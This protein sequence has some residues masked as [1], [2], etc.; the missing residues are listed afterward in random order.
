M[1][2][3]APD[4]EISIE[5]VVEAQPPEPPLAGRGRPRFRFRG[6]LAALGVVATLLV[7]VAVLPRMFEPSSVGTFERAQTDADQDVPMWLANALATAAGASGRAGAGAELHETLRR[8][9]DDGRSAFVFRSAEE[10]T[11]CMAVAADAL[12]CV[13]AVEF[14][15][16]GI[17]IEVVAQRDAAK[18]EGLR[19]SWGPQGG[20]RT[21]TFDYRDPIRAVPMSVGT[22]T[23]LVTDCMADRGYAV[24]P[25]ARGGVIPEIGD[26]LRTLGF[27]IN[28][29][30]CTARYPLHGLYFGP[31]GPVES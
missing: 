20:L 24:L 17:Q 2:S 25:T 4:P 10:D 23:E 26:D 11:V 16:D 9:A 19:Y 13:P 8:I 14:G 5:R 7:A 30:G 15:R 1:V 3:S 31:V 12:A 22:W 28:R 21:E 18:A 6:A 27:T 29:V